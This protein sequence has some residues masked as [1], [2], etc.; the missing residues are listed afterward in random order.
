MLEGDDVECEHRC[1]IRD[2]GFDQLHADHISHR[3]ERTRDDGGPGAGNV[4]AQTR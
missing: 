1:A 3:I 4:V 2:G